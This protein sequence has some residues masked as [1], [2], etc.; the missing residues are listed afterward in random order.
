[1]SAAKRRTA[2]AH[3]IKTRACAHTGS[4]QH[5]VPVMPLKTHDDKQSK[6]ALRGSA[7]TRC[8]NA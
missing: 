5:G 8:C 6:R 1:M 7:G 3:A 4:H 2:A